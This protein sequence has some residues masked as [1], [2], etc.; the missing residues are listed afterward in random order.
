MLCENIKNIALPITNSLK[1]KKM[2]MSSLKKNVNTYEKKNVTGLKILFNSI[3]LYK[4]PIWII[5][6]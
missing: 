1:E 4:A 3:Y 5:R 2:E 6:L